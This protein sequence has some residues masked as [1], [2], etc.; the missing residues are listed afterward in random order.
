MISPP[1][2]HQLRSKLNP[3]FIDLYFPVLVGEKPTL[4]AETRMLA[5]ETTSYCEQNKGLLKAAR[6]GISHSPNHM[7]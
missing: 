2:Q 4:S 6:F 1:H 5:A 3:I 7:D